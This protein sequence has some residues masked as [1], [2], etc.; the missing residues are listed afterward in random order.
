LFCHNEAYVKENLSVYA[1][2]F[3]HDLKSSKYI[4]C[5]EHIAG[6]ECHGV[7]I[8]DECAVLDSD[9]VG[10]IGLVPVDT[11]GNDLIGIVNL[12]QNGIDD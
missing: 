11:V 10:S 6:I 9:V 1:L 8:A 4:R 12:L 7:V 5:D 2:L 3:N